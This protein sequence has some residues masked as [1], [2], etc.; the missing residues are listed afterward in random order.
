MEPKRF[1]IIRNS[2]ESG[3]SGTGRIID[4]IVF[5]NGNTVICWRTDIEGSQHGY[6]SLGIYESFEAFKFIHIDSHPDNN[7]EIVW[8]THGLG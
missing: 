4:G 2:D 8:L 5:H 1:S 6:S 7:T 3:V